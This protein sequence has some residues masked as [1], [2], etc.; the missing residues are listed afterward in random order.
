VEQFLDNVQKAGRVDGGK[1]PLKCRDYGNRATEVVKDQY[2]RMNKQVE[3]GL[4]E[5]Q[6]VIRNRPGMSVGVAFGAGIVAGAVLG[7]LLRSDR[8]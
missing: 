3:S 5:A 1:T 4:E 8:A 7:L 2:G 6:E